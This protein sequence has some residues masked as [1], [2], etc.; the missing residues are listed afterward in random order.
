MSTN[1]LP[2]FMNES[3]DVVKYK[4]KIQIQN[5]LVTQVKPVNDVADAAA[6]AG[7]EM[8]GPPEE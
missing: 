3:P 4:Y 5:I 7:A 6:H 1:G 2:S 8:S